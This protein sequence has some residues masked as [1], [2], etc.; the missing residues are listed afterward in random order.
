VSSSTYRVVRVGS[1][2][3]IGEAEATLARLAAQGIEGLV[4][5]ER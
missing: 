5:R 3:T 2:A 1:Y 4:V